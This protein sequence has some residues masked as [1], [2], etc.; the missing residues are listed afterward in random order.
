MRF[1]RL[2][3]LAWS[4]SLITATFCPAVLVLLALDDSCLPSPLQFLYFKLKALDGSID[5]GLCAALANLAR[6]LGTGAALTLL[7]SAADRRIG[8]VNAR[9]VLKTHYPALRFSYM[10]FFALVFAASFTGDCGMGAAALLTTVGAVLLSVWFF[11]LSLILFLDSERQSDMIFGYYE[12]H[13]CRPGISKSEQMLLL[14]DAVSLTRHMPTCFKGLDRVLRAV[15]SVFSVQDEEAKKAAE[16]GDWAEVP[17]LSGLEYLKIAWAG[18]Q[19]SEGPDAGTYGLQA[20]I[21]HRDMLTDTSWKK[22]RASHLMLL[23]GAVYSLLPWKAGSSYVEACAKLENLCE[24]LRADE[25][26]GDSWAEQIISELAC[27]FGMVM[28]ISLV[29]QSKPSWVNQDDL[30]KAW[31]QYVGIFNSSLADALDNECED[32]RSDLDTL[33]EHMEWIARKDFGISW[34]QYSGDRIKFLLKRST[35]TRRE[36]AESLSNRYLLEWTIGWYT[37]T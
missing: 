33:L 24:A 14:L 9:D 13:I 37:R 17:L 27:A 31:T 19:K 6:I 5:A 10:L 34:Y 21:I 7:A 2:R 30:E 18:L 25:N 29:N 12:T 8:S 35:G 23:A 26:R 28:A 3:K 1:S 11:G 36:I 16:K 22:Q 15:I 4:C 32:R 20:D